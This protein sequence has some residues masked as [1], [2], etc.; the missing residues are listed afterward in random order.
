MNFKILLKIRLAELM[1]ETY[2]MF[3][4]KIGF[5]FMVNLLLTWYFNRIIRA[6]LI[7]EVKIVKKVV[8]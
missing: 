7:E 1:E 4:L 2:V 3:V 6:F 5:K 8:N